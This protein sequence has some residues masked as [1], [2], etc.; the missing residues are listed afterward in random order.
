MGFELLVG[1]VSAIASVGAAWISFFYSRRSHDVSRQAH[2]IELASWKQH[3]IGEL[4][5]WANECCDILSDAV[6]LCDLGRGKIAEVGFSE[7]HVDLRSKLSSL[8]DRGRWF[9]P[10][11]E[12]E[13]VGLHKPSAFQGFRDPI[14]DHLISTYRCLESENGLKFETEEKLRRKLVENQREFVASIQNVLDPWGQSSD[15]TYFVQRMAELRST[16]P[17]SNDG[18]KTNS[19]RRSRPS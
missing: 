4:R 12:S 8:V 3:Y 16:P 14:L 7:R 11:H 9:F 6:H 5:C 2:E 1:V 15:F 10:N 18:K 13:N 19:T 17:S